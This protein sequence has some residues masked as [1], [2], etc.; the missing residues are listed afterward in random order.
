MNDALKQQMEAEAAYY[1]ARWQA[2]IADMTQAE[3][4]REYRKAIQNAN[5]NFR[6]AMQF[7]DNNYWASHAAIEYR[8]AADYRKSLGYR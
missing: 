1:R 2:R 7:P 4:E 3:R 5:W 6:A 8:I